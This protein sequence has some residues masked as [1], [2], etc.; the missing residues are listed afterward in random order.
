MNRTQVSHERWQEAQAAELEY[1]RD[2]GPDGSD[3]NEWWFDKFEGYRAVPWRDVFHLLEVGCGPFAR[4]TRQIL[5]EH[6][7]ARPPLVTLND[8]LIYQYAVA[9]KAVRNL[10]DNQNAM[11]N[12]QPLELLDLAVQDAVI[13]INVLDHVQDVPKCFASL[14]KLVMPGGY[15]I[16]GQDLTNEEDCRQAPDNLTDVKHPILMDYPTICH[17][18]EQYETVFIKRLPREEGRNPKA[19]YSTLLFIGKKK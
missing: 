10:F 11:P 1:W 12:G 4:N 14:Q 5:H 8:P 6:F 7:Q 19:H 2:Q 18:I 16:L 3:W 13:C 17:Y 9:N 15:L